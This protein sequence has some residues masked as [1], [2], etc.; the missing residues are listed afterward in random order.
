MSEDQLALNDRDLTPAKRPEP[1]FGWFLPI[2]G[3]GEHIGTLRAE[4]EPTHEYLV[5]VAQAA[6]SAGYA[7]MLVPTRLVNG[8]FEEGAALAETW[9]TVSAT[10]P[11]TSRLR[12]LIAVRPGL[13]ATG[14]FAKMAA[15]LDQITRGRIDINVVPGGIEGDLE[16]LG[17]SS[18][19]DQ[20]YERAAEF[21]QACQALW[22]GAPVTFSGRYVRMQ[23]AICSP[24]PFAGRPKIYTG[25]A[26]PAALRLAGE[27]ADVL[28]AWIQPLAAMRTLVEAARAQYVANSRP[29]RLGLRTHIVLGKTE[30]E[31]WANADELLAEAHPLVEGQRRAAGPVQMIGRAAQTRVASD[32]RLS[33]RLWNGISRVRVNLGTAIVGTPQQVADELLDFWRLGFDEFILSAYPHLEEARTIAR[34]VVPRVIERALMQA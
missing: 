13:I 5:A 24:G 4:R 31:A 11:L 22:Q 33:S 28:L 1:S 15:T 20:R 3:D 10:A 12:F 27:C 29:P 7:N 9:T 19:H 26:S 16:R 6:E 14:L 34:E 32:F 21:I 17:E 18:G 8:S 23:N 2:D 30:G 25:G